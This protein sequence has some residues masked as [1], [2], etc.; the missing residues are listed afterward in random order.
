MHS[1]PVI[2]DTLDMDNG[3]CS[4]SGLKK[5]PVVFS[6]KVEEDLVLDP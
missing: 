2:I 1:S 5:F 3:K 6:P 4:H